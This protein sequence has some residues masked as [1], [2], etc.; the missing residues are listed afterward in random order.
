MLASI[1][2]VA[3]GV[4]T[5]LKEVILSILVRHNIQGLNLTIQLE[6]YPSMISLYSIYSTIGSRG[7]IGSHNKISARKVLS[8]DKHISYT[9]GMEDEVNVSTSVGNE[10]KYCL[11][12]DLMEAMHGYK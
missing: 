9:F 5:I 4:T 7:S 6:V 12:K 11:Q 1:F 2:Y 3:L 8:K 10:V